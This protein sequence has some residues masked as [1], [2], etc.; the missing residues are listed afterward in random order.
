MSRIGKQPIQIPEAVNITLKDEEIVISGPQGEIK[1]TLFPQ[2]HIEIKDKQISITRIKEDDK[3]RALHGLLRSLIANAVKGVKEGFEKRLELVG[4][5]YRVK[6]E[7]DK[8]VLSLGF[9]HPVVVD[10][11]E[12]VTLKVEGQKEIIIS[13]ID[14]QLV[15]QV[16]ANIRSFRKPEPYKGKGIRYKGELVRRKP[17]KAAKV[18]ASQGGA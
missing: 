11:L 13:G 6:K 5:G 3:T 18:G 12:G 2:L 9:S 10:T 15:G 4:T 17:G 8:L 7:D 14:K 1:E 16:A